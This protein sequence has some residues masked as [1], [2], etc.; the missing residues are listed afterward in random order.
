LYKSEWVEMALAHADEDEVR[1]AYNSALYLAARRRM[2]QHWADQLDGRPLVRPLRSKR[3]SPPSEKSAALMRGRSL[4]TN[5]VPRASQLYWQ[6][7]EIGGRA[8]VGGRP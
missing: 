8:F 3:A 2:L 7:S 1:G 5:V 4:G 6:R